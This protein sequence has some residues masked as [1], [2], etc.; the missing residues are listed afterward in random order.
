MRLAK[1]E[2]LWNLHSN[3]EIASQEDTDQVHFD[4]RDVDLSEEEE[5]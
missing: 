5:L 2:A 4:M 3:H 1:V